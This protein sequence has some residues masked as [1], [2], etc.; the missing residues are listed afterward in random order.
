[1]KIREAIIERAVSAVGGRNSRAYKDYDLCE[2]VIAD[3]E[4]V[5]KREFGVCH[6]AELPH[7]SLPKDIDWETYALAVIGDYELQIY[8]AERITYVNAGGA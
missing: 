3:I 1:M 2:W 7:V 8:I 4:N 6:I 5:L